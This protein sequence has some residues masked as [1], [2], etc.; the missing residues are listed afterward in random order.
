MNLFA[1]EDTE[2]KCSIGVLRK[3]VKLEAILLLECYAA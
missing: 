2:T 3:E 1:N